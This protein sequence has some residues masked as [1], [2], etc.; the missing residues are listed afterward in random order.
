MHGLSL[1]AVKR[2]LRPQAFHKEVRALSVG[3]GRFVAHRFHNGVSVRVRKP[4]V[5]V[6]MLG[7][8]S[9]HLIKQIHGRI[10]R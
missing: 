1:R 10:V 4:V 9:V 2:Q 7:F 6:V 8:D 5:S 3:V